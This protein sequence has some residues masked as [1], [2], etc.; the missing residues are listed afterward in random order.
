MKPL[1]GFASLG[2]L[3]VGFW[4]FG[5]FAGLGFGGLGVWGL[6]FGVWGLQATAVIVA[7]SSTETCQS[8]PLTGMLRGFIEE[9]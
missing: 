4:G 8:L 5:G 2:V 7:C 1:A 6:G 3:G 9:R